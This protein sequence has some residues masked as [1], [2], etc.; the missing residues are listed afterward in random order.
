MVA[1]LMNYLRRYSKTSR[2]EYRRTMQAHGASGTTSFEI[3]IDVIDGIQYV[4]WQ[5]WFAWRPVKTVA[6]DWVWLDKIYRRKNHLVFSEIVSR[7]APVKFKTELCNFV[8]ADQELVTMD[9]ICEPD[10]T[11]QIPVLLA[12]PSMNRVQIKVKPNRSY[13]NIQLIE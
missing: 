4:N 8:Y 11:R 5:S 7:S 13:S 1:G 3:K 6:G 2:A 10:K 12:S 9:C